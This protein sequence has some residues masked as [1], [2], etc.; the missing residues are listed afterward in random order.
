MLCYVDD[1]VFNNRIIIIT[2]LTTLIIETRPSE[3][4]KAARKKEHN[5]GNCLQMRLQAAIP[6]GPCVG[7]RSRPIELYH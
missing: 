6:H 2:I 4:K 5:R 3:D 1:V 7:I